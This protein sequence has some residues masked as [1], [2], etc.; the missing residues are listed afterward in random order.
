MALSV[1]PIDLLV[2]SYYEANN[3]LGPSSTYTNGATVTAW[4]DLN[5]LNTFNTAYVADPTYVTNAFNGRDA[6]NFASAS[7]QG[8]STNST[9]NNAYFSDM[10]VYGIAA[11]VDNTLGHQVIISKGTNNGWCLGINASQAEFRVTTSYYQSTTGLISNNAYNAICATWQASGTLLNLWLNNSQVITNTTTVT[12]NSATNNLSV[13]NDKKITPD[14][15]NG[16][17]MSIYWFKRVL[18]T[19]EK[20]LMDMY[21][22]NQIAKST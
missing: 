10:T 8:L 11:T 7:Q 21:V 13:G 14:L 2:D 22:L 1:H 6:I 3:A 5:G 9:T 18:A 17:I 16:K 4:N 15:I 19:W 20:S 12:M